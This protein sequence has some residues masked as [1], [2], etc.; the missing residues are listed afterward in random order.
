[1]ST[2]WL[3]ELFTY[4]QDNSSTIIAIS[5]LIVT[6]VGVYFT[7]KT[8]SAISHKDKKKNKQI[9]KKEVDS[10]TDNPPPSKPQKN[11]LHIK[12]T[13]HDNEITFEKD[14]NNQYS[15]ALDKLPD[16]HNH[17]NWKI[18]AETLFKY[19]DIQN[20]YT[21]NESVR[22]RIMTNDQ[23]IALL[24][25]HCLPHPETGEHLMQNN[26]VIEVSPDQHAHSDFHPL[27]I[28]N[29]L[30]VIPIDK[31]HKIRGDKH[32]SQIQSYLESH[33]QIKGVATRLNTPKQLHHELKIEKP[34]LLYLYAQADNGKILL[35]QDSNGEN[36]ISLEQLGRWLKEVGIKPI[37]IISLISN[38]K[39]IE[40]PK[41]LIDN[42]CL[43]WV[44][45][46]THS[47]KITKMEQQLFNVFDKLPSNGDITALIKQENDHQERRVQNI[48][49]N[50][51]QT[52]KLTISQSAQRL[53]QQFRV[54]LLRVVLGREALK[55]QISGGVGRSMAKTKMLVYAVSGAKSACPF[56]V[57]SQV[58][59]QLQ[60]VDNKFPV[61][62]YYFNIHI[63]PRPE[64]IDME[65][66]IDDAI[67]HGIKDDLQPAKVIQAEIS[68]R[69][70]ENQECCI[71]F[72]WFFDIP[73]DMQGK[74]NLTKWVKQWVNAICTE[75][76][77]AIPEK[78]LL[79]HALCLQNKTHEIAEN[80]HKIVY[81]AL[82]L[83]KK[84]RKETC[85][86]AFLKVPNTLGQLEAMEISNFFD[87][88]T[89]WRERLNLPENI[90]EN[91][92][93]ADWIHTRTNG[94][95]NEVIHKIWHEYQSNYRNYREY[96]KSL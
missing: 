89:Y 66:S 96:R 86:I 91:S 82:S 56:D 64:L 7:W 52:P 43:L 42:S 20:A 57:P 61:I 49:W 76:N 3:S 1:M 67:E 79:I 54:A 23:D 87:T 63:A 74:E 45:A 41:T 70:Y 13:K 77:N 5:G 18:L 50:S 46:V 11:W 14:L 10:N 30:V 33:F 22:L 9:K 80:T 2:K 85:N 26:W 90:N 21:S 73:E 39:L 15:V 93:F 62:S 27:I 95:F 17:P 38:K 58:Q 59:N 4:I 83:D 69:A 12:V 78:A 35:D 31:E 65:N 55:D 88:N 36:S 44:L 37:I 24:P 48:V 8:T 25:W 68:R 92:D 84:D 51:Y 34:D 32:Y 47:K 81:Q 71:A 19:Q 28:S 75:F 6:I 53:K 94:D 16:S 72:N 29:P 40:Y 60:Y